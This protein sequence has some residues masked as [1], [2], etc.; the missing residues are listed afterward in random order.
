MMNLNHFMPRRG[1]AM[2]PN[3]AAGSG[4]PCGGMAGSTGA[5]GAAGKDGVPSG[6]A[7]EGAGARSAPHSGQ[8]FAWSGICFQQNRQY[9]GIPPS[10]YL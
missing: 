6:G 2:T 1:A 7:A 8:N 9:M 4:V 5:A 10:V 3:A